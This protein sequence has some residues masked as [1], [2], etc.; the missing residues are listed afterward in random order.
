MQIMRKTW[1]ESNAPRTTIDKLGDT[2]SRKTELDVHNLFGRSV[3][4]NKP[5]G[6][7]TTGIAAQESIFGAG[8]QNINGQR[9]PPGASDSVDLYSSPKVRRAVESTS[10]LNAGISDSLFFSDDEAPEGS[11]ARKSPRDVVSGEHEMPEENE[12]DALLNEGTVAAGSKAWAE[13][14]DDEMEVMMEMDN[15]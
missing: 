1:V 8:P 12:L 7:I 11:A 5:D 13:E 4:K 2:N 10:K 9:T 3:D 14:F 15:M 6:D